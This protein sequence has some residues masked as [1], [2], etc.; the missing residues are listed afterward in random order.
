MELIELNK[1]IKT[2]NPYI[3]E[4]NLPLKKDPRNL[5]TIGSFGPV[6]KVFYKKTFKNYLF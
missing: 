1:L 5:I 3:N 2:G 6:Y 4:K